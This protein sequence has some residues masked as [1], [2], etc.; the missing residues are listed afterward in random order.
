MASTNQSPSAAVRARVNH[1]IIDSDGHAVEFGRALFECIAEVGG[2]GTVDRLRRLMPVSFGGLSYQQRREQRLWRGPWWALPAE[3]TLDLATATL[4][5]LLYERLDEI[6]LD[7]TVLYPSLALVFPEFEDEELRRAACRGVNL[8]FARYFGEYRDRM[9]P[10]ATVPMHS[11][12]EAI[13]E[14]EF[15]VGTLGFKAVVMPSFVRRPITALAGN[16]ESARFTKWIDTYCLDSEYDYDPV[17]AK[18]VELKVAPT[19]H[20]LSMGIG[21]RASISNYMYNHIGHFAASG[22]ALCKALFMGGVTQ[23]FPTLKFA[24]LEGGVAW[25]AGL[26]ADLI[27]HWE[28]RNAKDVE[29]YNPART[30]RELFVSLCQR[31]GGKLM[32]DR[33]NSRAL[34][35]P[36]PDQGVDLPS[37]DDWSRCGI[38]SA[39]DIRDLFVPHF[40]FGCEADDPMNAT[41]FDTSRNPFGARLN[42]IFSSD[43]GHWDVPDMREVTHEAHEMVNKGWIDESDFR[44][45]V[46]ENP[47][48]MWLGMNPDFF[49]GTVVEDAT[50]TL[51]SKA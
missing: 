34:T 20:S 25:G 14:L 46:F 15:A 12:R 51:M 3:N 9:A 47:G 23:R 1:P 5:R 31:Y 49:K 32:E 42:A 38:K 35:L 43:I 8:Y 40:Y 44:R 19:F 33:L 13:E 4:P 28:K 37:R 22:E 26:Y 11:P 27:G 7:F 16:T 41:A 2:P 17:W 18:C 24:F 45:F 50:R 39:E 10:V 48:R 6:G 29:R 30:D 21:F 36:V